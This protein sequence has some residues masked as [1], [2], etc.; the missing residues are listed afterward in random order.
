MAKLTKQDQKM[1]DRALTTN[2]GSYI[3]RT[4]AIIS[5]S[6]SKNTYGAVFELIERFHDFRN[7]HNV[8]GA[9]VHKTEL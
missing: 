2:D 9:L 7:F 1:Y 5:R 3:E 6:G 8:N 4:L